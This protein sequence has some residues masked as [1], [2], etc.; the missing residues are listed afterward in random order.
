[1]EPESEIT[2]NEV[3]SKEAD[4][5]QQQRRCFRMW[6]WEK[7]LYNACKKKIA[8]DFFRYHCSNLLH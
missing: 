7:S 1:M 3:C 2:E 6:G 4:I 8:I 5:V